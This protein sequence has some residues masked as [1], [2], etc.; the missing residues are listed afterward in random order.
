MAA[1]LGAFE[2]AVLLAVIRL[3][4]EA[5]GRVILADVQTRLGRDVAAGAVHATLSRLEHKGLLS[6]EVGEGSVVRAGRPRRYYR[7]QPQGRRALLEARLALKHLWRG[8]KSPL[9]GRA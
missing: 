3:R 7:L 1:V 6:S 9:K 4:N 5:Y 8:F 2:Q